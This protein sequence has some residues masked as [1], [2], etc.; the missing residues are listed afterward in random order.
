M[1]N[2]WLCF[3]KEMGVKELCVPLTL[4]FQSASLKGSEIISIRTMLTITG[5]FGFGLVFNFFL[6]SML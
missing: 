5:N 6:T 3:L 4:L 2:A 1:S